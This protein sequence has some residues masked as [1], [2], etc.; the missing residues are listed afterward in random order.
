MTNTR[1]TNN[2][3]ET[4]EEFRAAKSEQDFKPAADFFFYTGKKENGE[5]PGKFWTFIFEWV[6]PLGALILIWS[7][8]LIF[9]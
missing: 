6:V 7:L 5:N 3:I 4:A 9:L 2:K 8:F 1:I